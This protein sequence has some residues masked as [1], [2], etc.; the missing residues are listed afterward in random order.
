MVIVIMHFSYGTCKFKC[1]LI[2][3]C[4][5]PQSRPMVSI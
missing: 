4:K 2:S 3:Y 5:V 1:S